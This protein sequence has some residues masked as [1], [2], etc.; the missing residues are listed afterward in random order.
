[1][2][3]IPTPNQMSKTDKEVDTKKAIK[4]NKRISCERKNLIRRED[5]K[6]SS[7]S[8]SK[9]MYSIDSD[10]ESLEVPSYQS[11]TLIEVQIPENKKKFIVLQ[12]QRKIHLKGIR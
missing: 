7:S 1:M 5:E 4:E 2:S 10:R 9:S 11:P 6:E 8:S 3:R 12:P